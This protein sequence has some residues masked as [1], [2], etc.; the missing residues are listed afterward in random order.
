MALSDPMGWTAQGLEAVV[1]GA[2]KAADRIVALVEEYGVEKI[3]VGYPLNLDGSIGVRARITDEFI[4]QLADRV[5]S[6]VI[7]WDERYTTV[8]AGKS[9]RESG[10]K[11]SKNKEKVNIISAMIML[12][13]YLDYIAKSS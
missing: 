6:P 5:K 4:T 8:A 13:S 7:K 1:G 9:M 11:A 10:A 12:Q 3:V 2:A